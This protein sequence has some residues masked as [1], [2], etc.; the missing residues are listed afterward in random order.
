[1]ASK[2]YPHLKSPWAWAWTSVG[3]WCVAGTFCSLRLT[4]SLRRASLG[5][6]FQSIQTINHVVWLTA[7]AVTETWFDPEGG[8]NQ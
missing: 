5:F 7:Y 6:E 4:E 8:Y 3:T 1:M 2:T